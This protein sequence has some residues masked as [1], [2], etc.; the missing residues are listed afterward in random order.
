MSL[1]FRVD[2]LSLMCLSPC[3]VF[4]VVPFTSFVRPPL[5]EYLILGQDVSSSSGVVQFS[6]L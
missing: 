1:G 3:S 2:I 5:V 4:A 6:G